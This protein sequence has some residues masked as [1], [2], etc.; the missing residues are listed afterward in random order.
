LKVSRI[1]F[2]YLL[3]VFIGGALLAPWIW[4][5][6]HT[7]FPDSSISQQPFHRYVNRCLLGL[8][9]LLLWPLLRSLGIRGFDS[10]G[11]RWG[12][13]V[14]RE[15]QIGAGYG[16]ASLAAAVVV[17]TM[18][19]GRQWISPE[20][21]PNLLRRLLGFGTAAIVVSLMEETLFRGVLY[22][23]MARHRSRWVG[24]ITSSVVYAIVHFF[25]RP[26]EPE[27]VTWTS[28]LVILGK[29][30]AG[31]TDLQDLIP[32]FLSLVVVGMILCDS[33]ERTGRLWLGI[34]LHAGW[35]FWLKAYGAI[36]V[37]V[38]DSRNLWV[39]TSKLIDGWIVPLLLVLTWVAMRRFSF[40]EDTKAAKQR[41][42]RQWRS[43]R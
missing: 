19:G 22:G 20:I 29:M 10:L 6:I 2:L 34:G 9:I 8:A 17:A 5:W 35:I 13:G 26:P 38:S 41:C 42:P 12:S 7:T 14:V 27:V 3:L 4:T 16:L 25:R 18:V 39:G 28:G 31:F 40:P 1:F 30:L 21:A 15:I 36:S 24:A 33:R 37:P 32:G 23:A 11:L 43:Q